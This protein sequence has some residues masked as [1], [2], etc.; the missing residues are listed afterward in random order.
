MNDPDLDLA[1]SYVVRLVAGEDIPLP[2]IPRLIVRLQALSSK[3][4]LQAKY[5]MSFGDRDDRKRKEIYF[6][7]AKSVDD[8]VAAL[9]YLLK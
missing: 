2:K 7:A 6:T 4:S 8:L 3:F 9:K 1:L 5:Y